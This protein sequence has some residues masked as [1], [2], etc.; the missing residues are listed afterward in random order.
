MKRH[1][2]DNAVVVEVLGLA[3][4]DNRVLRHQVVSLL[5]DRHFRPTLQ[6]VAVGTGR[7]HRLLLVGIRLDSRHRLFAV[8]LL[9]NLVLVGLVL[10]QHVIAEVLAVARLRLVLGSLQLRE[11]RSHVGD[12]LTRPADV[13]LLLAHVIEIDALDEPVRA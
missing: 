11:L 8:P 9:A 13:G 3:H 5:D 2:P 6:D 12:G 10:L 4:P 7:R 1:P